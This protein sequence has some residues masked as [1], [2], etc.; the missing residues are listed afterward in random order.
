[1]L[2]SLPLCVCDLEPSREQ[3]PLEDEAETKRKLLLFLHAVPPS[4]P[5]FFRGIILGETRNEGNPLNTPECVLSPCFFAHHLTGPNNM[6]AG[7]K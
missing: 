6:S 1:M 4:P 2:L 3:F 7:T 5:P